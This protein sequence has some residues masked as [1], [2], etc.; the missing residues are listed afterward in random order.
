MENLNRTNTKK[1]SSKLFL[2][3]GPSFKT[4][5]LQLYT[6]L[7]VS[8]NFEFDNRANI[9][10]NAA[11]DKISCHFLDG[12]SIDISPQ[13]LLVFLSKVPSVDINIK[14][15]TIKTNALYNNKNFWCDRHF[16]IIK[17]QNALNNSKNTLEFIQSFYKLTPWNQFK[18]IHFFLHEKGHQNSTHYQI[19]KNDVQKVQQNVSEFNTLFQAIKKSKNRS[20]G[21]ASLKASNFQII[22]TCL[23]SELSLKQHNVILIFTKEDFLPQQE[24]DIKE[25]NVFTTYIKSFI[26]ISLDISYQKNKLQLIKQSFQSLP[27]DF[28]LKGQGHL[29]FTKNK[30]TQLFEKV[31]TFSQYLLLTKTTIQDKFKYIDITHKERIILLGELLNTLKHELSNPLFGL[32]LSA[33]LLILEKLEDDQID[34]LKEIALSINRCQAIIDSFSNLYKC[35]GTKEQTDLRQLINEV[36][37]LTKSASREI[38]KKLLIDE[39]ILIDTN[40]TWLAQILFNLIINSSQALLENG[41]ESPKISIFIECS[42]EEVIIHLK[43]NGPGVSSEKVKEIFTPF[44]TTKDKGNGLGLSISKSL[45]QKLGGDLTYQV[46]KIGAHFLLRLMR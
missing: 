35:D 12:H 10:L 16:D 43:D 6:K 5:F 21:Q 45:A 15:H 2:K 36:F 44:Y 40:R 20:F 27:F 9:L 18:T 19:F 14:H 41:T 28:S 17:T 7:L 30:K 29:F 1:A 46:D 13:N 32:Q 33:E 11:D 42:S 34:F 25:F 38:N 24:Q 37:T 22:G 23:A 26:D 4:K 31:T 3:L 8:E 39:D